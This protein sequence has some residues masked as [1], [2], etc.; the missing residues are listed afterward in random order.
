MRIEYRVII[1]GV[2]ILLAKEISC[3]MIAAR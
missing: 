3:E 1:E 2:R